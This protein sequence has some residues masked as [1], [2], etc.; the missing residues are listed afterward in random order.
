MT[1]LT[2]NSE[3]T[4]HTIPKFRKPENNRL[5][6]LAWTTV[7]S[8]NQL[9]ALSQWAGSED[10]RNLYEQLIKEAQDSQNV[11]QFVLRMVA[12]MNYRRLRPDFADHLDP[13]FNGSY[14]ADLD[15]LFRGQSP[16]NSGRTV[17]R[18]VCALVRVFKSLGDK[19]ED[20]VVFVETA[21]NR[22]HPLLH[23]FD[24]FSDHYLQRRIEGQ[25]HRSAMT[26]LPSIKILEAEQLPEVEQDSDLDWDIVPRQS[27]SVFRKLR[28][29]DYSR[30][31]YVDSAMPAVDIKYVPAVLSC[32][33]Y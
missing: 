16:G 10:G 1:G 3:M 31:P 17:E 29:Q 33:L 14:L 4:S 13:I 7:L 26:A 19:F 28:L 25:G 18:M 22:V 24:G 15:T 30:W 2:G 32:S 6:F 21:L 12:L 9:K 8:D 5:L 20:L 27:G 23:C 11:E